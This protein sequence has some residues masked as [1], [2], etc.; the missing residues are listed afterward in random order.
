MYLFRKVLSIHI[1][2]QKKVLI[3][4]ANVHIWKVSL[5]FYTVDHCITFTVLDLYCPHWAFNV[6]SIGNILKHVPW[7]SSGLLQ[8]HRQVVV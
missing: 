8:G 7:L 4:S 6:I 3:V 5:T 2:A 1:G